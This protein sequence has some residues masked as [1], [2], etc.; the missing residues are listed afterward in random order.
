MTALSNIVACKE[1]RKRQRLRKTWFLC[2][3]LSISLV[4]HRAP[5]SCWAINVDNCSGVSCQ[6]GI[7]HLEGLPTF[8]PQFIQQVLW[9]ITISSQQT[10]SYAFVI[11]Q[12]LLSNYRSVHYCVH[13]CLHPQDFLPLTGIIEGCLDGVLYLCLM[14]LREDPATSYFSNTMF[15]VT[16]LCLVL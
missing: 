6:Q 16:Q 1:E 3:V 13:I 2:S 11:A 9:S 10:L 14:S 7:L 12:C 15:L 5:G 4:K 8:G